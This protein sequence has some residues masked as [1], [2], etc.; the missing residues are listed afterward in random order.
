MPHLFRTL[1]GRLWKPGQAVALAFADGSKVEGIW[2]GSAQEER[3]KWWLGEPGNQLA[4][5]EVVSQ[6]ASRA[7]DTK[8]TI[9]GAAPVG[10]RLLFVVMAPEPGKHYRRAKMVTTSCNPAQ[11]AYFRHDRFSLFGTLKPDGTIAK[12]SPLPPPPP[13]PPAQGELFKSR[14]RMAIHCNGLRGGETGSLLV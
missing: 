2:V 9:W 11:V 7:K 4:Q 3:L 6:I 12:V 8:E 1:D 14:V 5:S 10:A 13:I